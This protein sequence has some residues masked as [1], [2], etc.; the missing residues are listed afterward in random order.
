VGGVYLDSIES[1][2]LNSG[3]SLAESFSDHSKIITAHLTA[4]GHVFTFDARR[5]QGHLPREIRGGMASCMSQLDGDL[6]TCVMHRIGHGGQP[7]DKFPAADTQ[8]PE[9]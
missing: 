9:S 2:L 6:S 5:P 8:L 1:G 3:G 7:R 4:I